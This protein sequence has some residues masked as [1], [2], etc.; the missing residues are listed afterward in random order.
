MFGFSKKERS[1]KT[2]KAILAMRYDDQGLTTADLIAD[3][4]DISIIEHDADET[5]LISSLGDAISVVAKEQHHTE[6]TVICYLLQNPKSLLFQQVV[7][8]CHALVVH[9]EALA[10]HEKMAGTRLTER[11]RMEYYAYNL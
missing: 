5:E 7:Q 1:D 3:L 2:A 10:S 6:A 9:K 11:K 4:V 8:V